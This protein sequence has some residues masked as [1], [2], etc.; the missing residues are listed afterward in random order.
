MKWRKRR[1]V[2]VEGGCWEITGE[3][4]K[5][6]RCGSRGG[7]GTNESNQKKPDEDAI[8]YIKFINI[9]SRL[10]YPPTFLPPLSPPHSFL[11]YP[12]SPVP[13]HSP[14]TGVT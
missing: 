4:W 2:V 8:I 6:S 13:L 9:N 3:R 14:S 10:T 1:C 7:E 11:T 5:E 12:T